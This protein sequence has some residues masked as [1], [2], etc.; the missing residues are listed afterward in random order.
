MNIL[1]KYINSG[2]Q[3]VRHNL[4][5]NFIKDKNLNIAINNSLSNF[6][7]QTNKFNCKFYDTE[8]NEISSENILNIN[9]K[10]GK[11]IPLIKFN[12]NILF[13]IS[14]FLCLVRHQK[15]KKY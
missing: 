3:G 15:W 10:N 7:S 5:N 8:S 1:K 13:F 4:L 6:N 2:I 9:T 14:V 11:I 12:S